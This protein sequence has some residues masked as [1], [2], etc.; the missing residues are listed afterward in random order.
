MPDF[1]TLV[2]FS[3]HTPMDRTSAKAEQ[4]ANMRKNCLLN[5]FVDGLNLCRFDCSYHNLIHI[6]GI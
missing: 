5:C 1:Y 2:E 3:S 6:S 4:V